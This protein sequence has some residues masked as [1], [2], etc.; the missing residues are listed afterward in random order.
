[1]SLDPKKVV[2]SFDS[3]SVLHAAT[4]AALEH[5]PFSHLGN[6]DAVAALVR[7]AGHL[8]WPLLKQLYARIGGAEGVDPD[9][10]GQVD[11]AA[12]AGAFADAYTAP[13]YPAVLIGSSN[14]ALTHLAA[15]MGAPWLP[16]T[17][18]IPVHH[19]GDPKRPD[20]A[21]EFGRR[22]AG[23]L[24]RANPDVVLHQMHDSAQDELM[25]ARMTYFRV[26]WRGLPEAYER[27]LSEHLAP[28]APVLLV[29]DRSRWPVTRVGE[30]HVF[31]TGGRGGLTP[32]Q[33]LA[34]PHAPH[35]D[36][37]APEAEWGAEPTFTQAVHEWCARTG[38]PCV[39]ITPDGPQEAAHPVAEI[40]RDWTRARGGSADRLIVPSFVLG[41]PWRTILTGR[42]PFWT[43][44]PV[45]S[46]LESL[47]H[48]LSVTEPYEQADLL[49]FQHGAQSPGVVSP[50]EFGSVLHRHGVVPR[51]IAVDPRK[52]PHD[53][54]SLAKYGP[55][56][57]KE[58][59]APIPSV[60]LSPDVAIAGLRSVVGERGRPIASD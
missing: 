17:V 51:L 16:N 57:A 1:V 7:V 55:V 18:L 49:V 41:D 2:A 47:E 52:S 40:L 19:V 13:R 21:L 34:T 6:P 14:G 53:I 60:P 48:H 29:D 27:F 26:K 44:F 12:V 56:L 43:F 31:Q 59:P 38:H 24:L 4:V 25:V 23:P 50:R 54:G 5:R 32:E 58:P 30:R 46:A 33:N 11:L 36:D 3:A 22:T 39:L 37:E 35:A 15:A 42:T 10:L 9:L 8:P 20:L 28:G 45:R